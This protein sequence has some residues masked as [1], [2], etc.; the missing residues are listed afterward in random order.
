MS[1]SAYEVVLSTLI[2]CSRNRPQ[3]LWET[4]QSVLAGD[5]L[6]D[7]LIIVDQ[8]DV[9]HPELQ[10]LTL[11]ATHLRYLWTSERGL[12]RARNLGISEANHSLVAFTDDDV[13]VDRAWYRTLLQALIDG[14]ARAIVTGQVR[15]EEGGGFA[16]STRTDEARLVYRGRVGQDVLYTASMSAYREALINTGWFDERLG[17]GTVFPSAE[18]NDL[19]FRLLEAGYSIVYCPEAVIYHRAW[20]SADD[21]FP[22]RWRYGVG[23][24]AFYCKHMTLHDPYMVRRLLADMAEHLLRA[25][26]TCRKDATKAVGD[27]V[28]SVGMGFGAVRWR[29]RRERFG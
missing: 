2:I 1:E 10:T 11:P 4:V 6:P 12:S 25:M 16:P 21:F 7:E 18:D 20:R 15:P 24:G 22:L 3:L 17:P 27:I 23:R 19:G 14:G 8:S 26:R 29:L 28:L 5:T 13:L 9:P